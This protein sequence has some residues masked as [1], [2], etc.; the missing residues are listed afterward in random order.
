M[1]VRRA[2][3]LV[4]IL[5]VVVILGILA[6]LVIPQFSSATQEAAANATYTDLQKMR[7]AIGVWQTRN[8]GLIPPIT[9]SDDPAEAWGPLVGLSGDYLLSAPINAWVGG[10]NS[11]RVVLIEGYEPDGSWTDEQG[12][13]FDPLTGDLYASGFDVNDRPIPKP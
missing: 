10:P 4:E 11:R 7:K 5:I 3:T 8:N 6:A 13:I 2:F 12:W 1:K 9:D